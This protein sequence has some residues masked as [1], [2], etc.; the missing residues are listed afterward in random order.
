MQLEKVFSYNNIIRTLHQQLYV[1]GWEST[2]MLCKS[3]L[4]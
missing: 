2:T 1:L 3:F 4:L